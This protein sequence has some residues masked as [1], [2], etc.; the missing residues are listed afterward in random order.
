MDP[1]IFGARLATDG[2]HLLALGPKKLLVID[3]SNPAA[4]RVVTKLDYG[5]RQTADD[6]EVAAG[7]A[8]VPDLVND[9]VHLFDLTSLPQVSQI[10]TVSIDGP[11]RI[12]GNE[13]TLVIRPFNDKSL[14]L[15]DMTSCFANP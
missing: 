2:T 13:R 8:I 1:D 11:Y 3:V 15:F 10:G 4:M 12:V 14:V 7:L 6:F 5:G 9:K